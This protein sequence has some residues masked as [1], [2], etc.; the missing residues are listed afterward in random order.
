VCVCSRAVDESFWYILDA[1]DDGLGEKVDDVFST[2]AGDVSCTD[3]L[4]V[5]RA[6]TLP[7]THLTAIG[8][9]VGK[10]NGEL[11]IC[12]HKF[13]TVRHPP[14]FFSHLRSGEQLIVEFTSAGLG[15]SQSFAVFRLKQ[16]DFIAL[17]CRHSS[18]KAY[19][20]SAT[21]V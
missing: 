20:S 11:P 9:D 4:K 3:L 13:L 1:V 12:I 15:I 18:S 5:G 19:S 8:I 14:G 7:A 16:L 10:P 21:E 17:L 6:A 2:A